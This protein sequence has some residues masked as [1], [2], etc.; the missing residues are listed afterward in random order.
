MAALSVICV[1]ASVAKSANWNS[2]IGRCPLTASPI[3]YP[4]HALS[5][6]GVLK[7]LARPNSP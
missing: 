5:A 6:S 7:T 3:A 1:M 2:S 4:V